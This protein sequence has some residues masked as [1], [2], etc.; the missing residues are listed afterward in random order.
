[1]RSTKDFTGQIA[2]LE[3]TIDKQATKLSQQS[4][5]LENFLSR[6]KT[7][8][9]ALNSYVSFQSQTPS[10]PSISDS[11]SFSLSPSAV[12]SLLSSDLLQQH[13]NDLSQNL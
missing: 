12:G 10:S 3:Q 7:C 5:S 6:W 1:M 8:L 11:S 13:W 4:A 2:E 9:D